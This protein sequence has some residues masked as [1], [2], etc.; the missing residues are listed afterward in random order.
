[1]IVQSEKE[2]F[3]Y[4]RFTLNLMTALNSRHIHFDLLHGSL[5]FN[6]YFVFR[7]F[8][9]KIKKILLDAIQIQQFV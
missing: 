8:W 3:Y 2:I 6:A 5:S 4:F 9:I 1:M 7:Y